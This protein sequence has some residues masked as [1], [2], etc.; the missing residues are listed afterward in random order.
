MGKVIKNNSKQ[1]Y[2][3]RVDFL[4]NMIVLLLH[5]PQITK[6]LKNKLFNKAMSSFIHRVN[7]SLMK[8]LWALLS[9]C[10]W[11]LPLSQMRKM[12][13]LQT[14]G[15]I[16]SIS[17]EWLM[18]IKLIMVVGLFNL[19]NILNLE[20]LSCKTKA[21]QFKRL[22]STNMPTTISTHPIRIQEILKGPTV[23][24]NTRN[25]WIWKY[26]WSRA[27]KDRG[28]FWLAK[29]SYCWSCNP[30]IES[31][32]HRRTFWSCFL[33]LARCQQSQK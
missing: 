31:F 32:Q 11:A 26:Y 18:C 19:L 27:S 8:L 20:L 13:T 9:L 33:E 7:A 23:C 16:L 24:L 30:F 2:Q 14:Y 6:K 22:Q 3:S 5:F 12:H 21:S 25:K 1:G 10:L 4:Q 15:R 17:M 28:S 29:K